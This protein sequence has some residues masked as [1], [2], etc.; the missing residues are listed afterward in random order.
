[1]PLESVSRDLITIELPVEGEWVKVLPAL[2][3]SHHQEIATRTAARAR[4]LGLT[5]FEGAN[6]ALLVQEA[7]YATLSVAIREWSHREAITGESVRRLDDDSQI[8]IFERLAELYPPPRTDD[9]RKNLS[10]P[11]QAQSSAEVESPQNSGGSQ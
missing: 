3:R 1:M 6:D 4:A 10:A 9:G 8:A 2:G 7:S 5:V 11:G